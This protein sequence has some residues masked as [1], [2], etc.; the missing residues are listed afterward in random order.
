MCVRGHFIPIQSPQIEICF[1]IV[2]W[3]TKLAC[4]Q[5]QVDSQI[6]EVALIE[7]HSFAIP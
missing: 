4:Q 7:E 2:Q 5:V 3:L 6:N 1:H